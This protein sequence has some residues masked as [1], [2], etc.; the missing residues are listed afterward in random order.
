MTAEPLRTVLRSA[1][2]EHVIG[3]AERFTL[4]G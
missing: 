4:M 1:T 2:R 3:H